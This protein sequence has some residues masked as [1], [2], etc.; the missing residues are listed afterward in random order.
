MVSD[1]PAGVEVK[2]DEI[3]QRMARLSRDRP[4]IH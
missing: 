2:R 4:V 3:M 1:R